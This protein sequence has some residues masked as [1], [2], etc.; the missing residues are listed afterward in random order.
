MK[1]LKNK[2]INKSTNKLAGIKISLE[3]HDKLRIEA[4][5]KRVKMQD[6]S[7]QIFEEHFNAESNK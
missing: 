7:N 5:K 2:Q 1:E 3:N 4:A 6:L